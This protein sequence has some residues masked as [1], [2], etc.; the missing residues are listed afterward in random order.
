METNKPNIHYYQNSWFYE[1]FELEWD[2]QP[3]SNYESQIQKIRYDFEKGQFWSD[4][5]N[6]IQ[7]DYNDEYYL[8][9]NQKLLRNNIIPELL[10]KPYDSL[11]DKSFRKN[12]LN[13]QNYP[14]E[15]EDGWIEPNKWFFQIKDLVRT[16]FV[17]KYLDGVE[18]IVNKI[19]ELA[20]IHGYDFSVEYEARDVGYYAAHITIA[21]NINI[22]DLSG[23]LNEISFSFEIQISTELQETIKELTH[24]IYEHIRVSPKIK[25]DMKWQWD[26]QSIEFKSYYI[27]HILHYI[28]GMLIEVR[29]RQN[30]NIRK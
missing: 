15:P 28:E 27:G 12:I 20:I 26:H 17:V 18:F 7:K 9:Y 22:F 10:Y 16:T 2:V 11:I 6:Y 30:Q 13:N 23:K 19:N 5:I 3:K 8:I 1:K 25:M 24:R 14:N 21:K 29:D 4:L